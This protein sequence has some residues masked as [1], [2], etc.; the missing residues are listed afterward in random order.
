[1]SSLFLGRSSSVALLVLALGATAASS[2]VIPKPAM[3]AN[4]NEGVLPPISSRSDTSQYMAQVSPVNNQST[5]NGS[6]PQT[7]ISDLNT[8]RAEYRVPQGTTI[9]VEYKVSD[10]VVVAPG[11][12]KSLTLI[13]AQ[14]IQNSKGE[15]L[16]PKGSQIE[17]QIVP[18]YS[19]SSF[20]GAQFVAQRLSVGNQ[21][22][23]SLNATS[24]L[25]TE[26]QSTNGV[27]SL[28]RTIGDA[29]INTAA[30]V[31]LGRVTGQGGSIG[32]MLSQVGSVGGILGQARGVGGILGNVLTSRGSNQQPNNSQ[33][34][35]DPQKDLQL[36]VGSDFYVNTITK[37]PNYSVNTY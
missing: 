34:L 36:T 26:Q 11:E 20:L 30:Q 33:I 14:D 25:L 31:L 37:T 12:T 2:I 32:D 13:V 10:K 24:L 35:I 5:K 1:M 8:Q 18:R 15:I 19:G 21:S 29:A 9:K 28:Q 23:N 22:Y 3:A 6:T 17:G 4:L 7:V 16:I 27:G